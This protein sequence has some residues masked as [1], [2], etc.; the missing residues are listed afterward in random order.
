MGA[1]LEEA[2]AGPVRRAVRAVL[3]GWRMRRV[4]VEAQPGLP[5]PLARQVLT[6]RQVRLCVV[7]M[8]EEE[9]AT[10]RMVKAATAA[11]AA[12]T[13]AAAA[14]AVVGRQTVGTVE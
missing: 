7:V 10:I 13:A 4:A 9:A 11:R 1:A 3:R 5:A 8:E 12:L 2:A 6:G 14:A